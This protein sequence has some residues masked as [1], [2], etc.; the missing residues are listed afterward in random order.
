LLVVLLFVPLVSAYQVNQPLTIN[1]KLQYDNGSV[2]SDVLVPACIDSIYFDGNSSLLV[3]DQPMTPG[4]YHS[5]VFTPPVV[6]DY[7]LSVICT[8]N[9][10]TARYFETIAITPVITGSGSGGSIGQILNLNA[11]IVPDKSS[12][13]VNLGVDSVLRFPV[14]YYANGV[15]ANSNQA[16]WTITQNDTAMEKGTFVMQ[17]TGNYQFD[18]DFKNYAPGDYTVYLYFDGRNQAVTVHV[19]S[20][21]SDLLSITGWVLTDTGAVSPVKAVIA[22]FFLILLVAAII[23]FFRRGASR[24]R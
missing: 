20:I 14:Q 2:L 18:F 13:T 4:T 16:T 11:K 19:I 1:V 9:N 17:S 22:L 10:E 8:F 7:E 6:G 12:Y 21:N 15:L 3:R 5:T 24:R 23:L